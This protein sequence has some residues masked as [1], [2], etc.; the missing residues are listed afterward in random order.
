MVLRIAGGGYPPDP[1]GKEKGGIGCRRLETLFYP[2]MNILLNIGFVQEISGK[3][4]K[5]MQQ[6]AAK[7]RVC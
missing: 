2:T 4:R 6:R 7:A 3:K 1:Y 5:A